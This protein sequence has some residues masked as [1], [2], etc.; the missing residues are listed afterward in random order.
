M[1][2]R[3]CRFLVQNN[4]ACAAFALIF[5]LICGIGL[6]GLALET[7]DSIFFD[8]DNPNYVAELALQDQ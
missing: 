8:L 4:L 6:G 2:V 1:A 5:C 3:F 7:D